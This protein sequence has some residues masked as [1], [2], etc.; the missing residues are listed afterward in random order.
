MQPR[1]Q[2][3]RLL[4]EGDTDKRV[5]PFLMEANGVAWGTADRPAVYIA[6]YGGIDE[7]L[8]AGAIEGELSASGLEALGIVADA[9]GDA[10]KRWAQIR[11]LCE[12][13]VASLPEDLPTEGLRVT[14]ASGPRFGVWIMPDNRSKGMLEDLLVQLV[15]RRIREPVRLGCALRWRS[16]GHRGAVQASATDQG[17]GPYMVGLAGRAGKVIAS[18]G[19]SPRFG[20]NEGGVQAVRPLVPKPVRGVIC[21]SSATVAAVKR[22]NPKPNGPV[23]SP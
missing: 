13:Q 22:V 11:R 16:G 19:P 6:P 10:R 5:I 18:S 14:H 1:V 4:V 21:R 23:G 2:P 3:K 20:S 15:P 7:M 9:N 12:A 8:K 17:E